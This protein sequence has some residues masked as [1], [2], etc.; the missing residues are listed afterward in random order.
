MQTLLPGLYW[1]S[2]HESKG[3]QAPETKASEVV[4]QPHLPREGVFKL[5]DVS[6]EEQAPVVS[7]QVVQL[8]GQKAQTFA[9]VLYYVDLHAQV[10][11]EAV[12]VNVERQALH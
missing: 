12:K 10:F 5:N 1:P 7:S 11:V 3:T 8:A 4:E 9:D 2:G 6:H